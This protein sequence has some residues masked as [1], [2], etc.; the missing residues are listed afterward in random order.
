MTI[1]SMTI[2]E[3]SKVTGISYNTLKTFCDRYDMPKGGINSYLIDDNFKTKFEQWNEEK[4]LSVIRETL[5]REEECLNKL[6]E[7]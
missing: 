6:M 5:K 4:R 1:R 2:P 7:L 3:L